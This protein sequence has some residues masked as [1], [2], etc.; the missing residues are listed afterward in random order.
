MHSAIFLA[1]AFPFF[2]S[3]IPTGQAVTHSPTPEHLS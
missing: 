1:I 2:T 3:N